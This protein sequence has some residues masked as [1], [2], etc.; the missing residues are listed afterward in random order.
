MGPFPPRRFAT[1]VGSTRTARH[2]PPSTLHECHGTILP[3]AA[4]H[5]ARQH[6]SKISARRSE[7]LRGSEPTACFPGKVVYDLCAR[8]RYPLRLWIRLSI[9][10][11]SIR[12]RVST[13]GLVYEHV[14][15]RD[16]RGHTHTSANQR[17]THMRPTSACRRT[18]GVERTVGGRRYR[19]CDYATR[20]AALG[21]RK[22]L[23]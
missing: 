15:R 17:G 23:G 4:A 6:L 22:R 7:R 20:A 2:V 14:A 11:M 13:W 1:Q 21:A 18:T 16:A 3:L 10:A 5:A 12:H 8:G 19:R 9:T